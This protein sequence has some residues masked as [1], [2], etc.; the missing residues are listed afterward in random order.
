MACGVVLVIGL[1]WIESLQWNYLGHDR[2]L[3][4]FGFFEQR[5]MRLGDSL[6]LFA[7]IENGRAILGAL[8]R[9]PCATQISEG[10]T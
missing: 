2:A 3:E 4:N 5:D 7:A 9:T 6:L 1:G 10:T 8:V